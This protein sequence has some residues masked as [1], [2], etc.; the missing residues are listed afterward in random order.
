[1][2]D[3]PAELDAFL[4]ISDNPQ[5]N[6][7]GRTATTVIGQLQSALVAVQAV[8]GVTGSV[9]AGTVEKR[10]ADLLAAMGTP[11]IVSADAP[12]SPVEGTLWLDTSGA[13]SLKV[14]LDGSPGAW[15][16]IVSSVNGRAGAV[17]LTDA[18]VPAEM[19]VVS[20][21]SKTLALSDR[22]L[23]QEWTATGAK[24]LTINT[25]TGANAG[26]YHVWNHAASGNLTLSPSGVT[27]AAPK[28]GSLILE[29]GDV[30][31]LKRT[32]TNA[33]LLIGST[34]AA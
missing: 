30:G 10:L 34:K 11:V 15:L 29:P 3:F 32:G 5:M 25:D 2:S 20:G 18:D 26:E 9:V 19:L 6:A 16:A 7:S 12:A 33:F 27:V 1:M 23:L 4:D 8:I 14:W 13:P 17:S 28:G 21:S 22:G 24:T 31:T